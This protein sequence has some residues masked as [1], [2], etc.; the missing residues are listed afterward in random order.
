MAQQL[1]GTTYKD[2]DPAYQEAV[3]KQE[4]KARRR[5]QN[6]AAE[7]V[8]KFKESGAETFDPKAGA[9]DVDSLEDFDL[10]ATGAGGA[11]GRYDKPGDF[12]MG[13]EGQEDTYGRGRARLSKADVKGLLNAKDA[14]GNQKFTAQQIMDYG[15]S[16][17][18]DAIFGQKAQAF[19][20]KKM[21]QLTGGDGTTTPPENGGGTT[22]PPGTDGG[23][24]PPPPTSTEP[25][26]QID[27]DTNFGTQR[28]ETDNSR[29][30]T[31]GTVNI[32]GDVNG[33][34]IDASA[35]DYS[36]NQTFNNQEQNGNSGMGDLFGGY[37]KADH[38]WDIWGSQGTATG[39][40]RNNDAYS[41]SR[42][43]GQAMEGMQLRERMTGANAIIGNMHQASH[44]TINHFAN[45]ANLSGYGLHQVY[46]TAAGFKPTPAEKIEPTWKDEDDD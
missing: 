5:A 21:G 45:L 3:S 44:N 19:L 27:T 24:T 16:L 28:Q 26:E 33:S 11:L 36:I 41:D 42:I 10:R 4:Y 13:A 31:G 38:Q 1:I 39:F 14:D 34:Y 8:Q 12:E 23:T 20:Q 30:I 17:S 2:M 37:G 29:E 15:N 6:Q 32:D 46:D 40:L 9:Y 7:R 18:G 25:I 22:T 35:N 43:K